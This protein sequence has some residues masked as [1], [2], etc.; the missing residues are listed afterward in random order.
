MWAKIS[1]Q[2]IPELIRNIIDAVKD[3]TEDGQEYVQEIVVD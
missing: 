1:R 3:K 2:T